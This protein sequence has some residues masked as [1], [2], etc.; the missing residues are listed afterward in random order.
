MRHAPHHLG[1]EPV[2]QVTMTRDMRPFR[3][4]Q[5]PVVPD[6]VA[7]QLV[8]EGAAVNPR[9]WPAQEEAMQPLPQAAGRY[10]T[11]RGDK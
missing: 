7:T 9:A 8:D 5:E 3:K 6:E 1:D 2:K 4:G 11:K 10:K